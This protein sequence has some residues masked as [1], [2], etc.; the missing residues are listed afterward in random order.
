MAF[1]RSVCGFTPKISPDCF[2]A[3]TAVIIGDIEIGEGCSI[4]Y[5]AVLRGDVNSIRVGNNVNIQDG[6]VLHTLF[7][8]SKVIIGDNVTIGHNACIHGARIE[9]NVLI[10]IGAI[11]LDNAVVQQNTIIAAGALVLDSQ[12]CES[13]AVYA[14]VPARK[15][16]EISSQQSE[17]MIQRIATNYK[18]YASWYNE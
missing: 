3:E 13:N 15:V 7:E 11:V 1:V 14:G 16:K 18:M 8:R 2:M 9:D 10:G 6:A 12:V 4:W 17:N 5:N